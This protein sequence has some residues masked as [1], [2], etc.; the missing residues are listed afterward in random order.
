MTRKRKHPTQSSIGSGSSNKWNE[1]IS[2]KRI[3]LPL[4]ESLQKELNYKAWHEFGSYHLYK[5]SKAT[6][7]WDSSVLRTERRFS[8]KALNDVKFSR[9]S[10]FHTLQTR[11]HIV[12]SVRIV[13]RLFSHTSVHHQ[14][15]YEKKEDCLLR[16]SWIHFVIHNVTQK[17]SYYVF[18]KRRALSNLT[19]IYDHLLYASKWSIPKIRLLHTAQPIGE[20]RDS[21]SYP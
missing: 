20:E 4:K 15:C 11:N 1:K 16:I 21:G 6:W 7:E 10:S 9:R 2:H 12:T 3:Y 14:S 8:G 13:A 19:H 18:F 17:R 5:I